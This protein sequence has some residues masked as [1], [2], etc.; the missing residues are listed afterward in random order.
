[1]PSG[2][3]TR[4]VGLGATPPKSIL[5][6]VVSSSAVQPQCVVIPR[7]VGSRF[8]TPGLHRNEAVAGQSLMELNLY[9][10]R[11]VEGERIAKFV[12][13]ERRIELMSARGDELGESLSTLHDMAQKLDV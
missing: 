8:E 3:P 12:I 5:H 7:V 10:R 11:A 4:L 13:S 6:D 1:M 9:R 2:S